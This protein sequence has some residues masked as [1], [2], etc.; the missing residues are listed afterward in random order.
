MDEKLLKLIQPEWREA[1][2]EFVESGEAPQAFLDYLDSHPDALRAAELVA[3]E[4]AG[5][6]RPFVMQLLA[7]GASGQ[8]G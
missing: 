5:E 2:V 1:F 8:L 7:A 4:Q 3:D 6:M